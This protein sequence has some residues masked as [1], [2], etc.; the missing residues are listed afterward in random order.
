MKRYPTIS[1]R[2]D[3]RKNATA[4]HEAPVEILVSYQQKKIYLPTG[5]RLKSTE[6]KNGKAV[7]RND[8]PQ[9]NL[10][11]EEML[12]TTR[13]RTAELYRNGNFSLDALKSRMRQN[14]SEN[15][16]T[17]IEW[18]KKR[19]EERTDIAET[20]KKMH[21]TMIADAER[22]GLFNSWQ[23]FTLRSI[24][25][26]DMHIKTHVKAQTTVH[27]YH[28]RMKPYINDAIKHGLLKFSPYMHFKVKG[29][30]RDLSDNSLSVISFSITQT[31]M[32]QR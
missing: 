13:D 3:R 7:K 32:T 2:F 11:I 8:A 26:W 22:S 17:P 4:T 28:K 18:I 31:S 15:D 5:V 29:E 27:G 24:E 1:I 10:L 12:A 6:W 16:H 30:R 14:K 25:L 20:T 23:D 21:R 19:I 9:C